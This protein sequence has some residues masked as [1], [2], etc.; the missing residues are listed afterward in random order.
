MPSAEQTRDVSQTS[1]PIRASENSGFSQ[2]S[3][4]SQE[5]GVQTDIQDACT[6]LEE[7]VFEHNSSIPDLN[8]VGMNQTKNELIC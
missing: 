3:K 1:S 7:S 6:I 4:S 8:K 5:V 2:C